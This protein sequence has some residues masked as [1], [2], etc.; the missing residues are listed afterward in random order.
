MTEQAVIDQAAATAFRALR[1]RAREEYGSNTQP[2]LVVYAVE[3]F[4]RRLAI[5]EHAQPMVV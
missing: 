3:S 1:K 2:L 4:L 5:S